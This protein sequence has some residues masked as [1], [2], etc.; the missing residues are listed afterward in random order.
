MP[1]KSQYEKKRSKTVKKKTG[2]HKPA[3]AEPQS[4]P[5]AEAEAEAEPASEAGAEVH[6]LETN[7]GAAEQSSET[8]SAACG[9]FRVDLAAAEFGMYKCGFKKADHR[10]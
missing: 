8:P 5:E 1:P 7:G 4:E 3:E 9:N 6:V 10:A 2:T